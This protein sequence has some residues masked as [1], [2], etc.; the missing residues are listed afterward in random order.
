MNSRLESA[1]G[2]HG[3]SLFDS[4]RRHLSRPSALSLSLSLA[5]LLLS[6]SLSLA[7]SLSLSL[8]LSLSLYLSF[9]TVVLPCPLRSA[10]CA[11]THAD[12]QIFSGNFSLILCPSLA[13]CPNITFS[14]RLVLSASRREALVLSPSCAL[15]W[16]QAVCPSKACFVTFQVA[17]RAHAVK[18]YDTCIGC[19]FRRTGGWSMRR[20]LRGAC[21]AMKSIYAPNFQGPEATEIREKLTYIAIA[22]S[23]RLCTASM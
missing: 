20:T 8:L 9:I 21:S 23:A 1:S 19:C 7:L 22:D 3:L 16:A 5:L 12:E 13:C 18:I 15:A 4:H 11:C 2:F 17:R 6:L 10:T 14:C